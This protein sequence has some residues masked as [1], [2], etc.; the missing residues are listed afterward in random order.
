MKQ[1]LNLNLNKYDKILSLGS[2]CTFSVLFSL[3]NFQRSLFD[4]NLFTPMWSIS[5]LLLNNFTDFLCD[6]EYG[7]FCDGVNGIM[8]YDKKYAIRIV[9]NDPNSHEC[10]L[11]C[12]VMNTKAVEF[13][14]LLKTLSGNVLFLRHQEP[15]YHKY[16]GKRLDNPDFASYYE[17]PELHYVKE[18]SKIIKDINP[19]ISFKILYMSDVDECFFD[20]EYNIVGI[21]NNP[22]AEFRNKDLH[23]IMTSHLNA[24]SSFISSKL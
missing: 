24:Y 19:N 8:L 9:G 5:N 17:K 21:P 4:S 18:F 22:L 23:Y 3:K 12:E 1:N 10:K 11:F 14:E 16:Y 13:M 7:K 6:I 2:T 15:S 20:D